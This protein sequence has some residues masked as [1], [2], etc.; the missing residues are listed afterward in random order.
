MQEQ[1]DDFTERG[2]L[3]FMADETALRSQLLA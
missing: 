2:Y 3:L 1:T